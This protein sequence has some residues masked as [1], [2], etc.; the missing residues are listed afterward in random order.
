LKGGDTL[1]QLYENLPTPN[2]R[3]KIFR[4]VSVFG[5]ENVRVFDFESAVRGEG[6]II[7]AFAREAGLSAHSAEFLASRAPR[8]NES[9]SLEAARILDSLNRRR[10]LFAASGARTTGRAGPQ[11]EL[12]YIRRI[13]GRKFDV[14]GWVKQEIA[15]RSREDVA[16]LNETFGLDLYRDVFSEVSGAVEVPDAP[17]ALSDAAVDGIAEVLGELVAEATFHRALEQ[18]R[19]ALAR[20]NLVRAER[21]LR[22]AARLDPDAAQPKKLLAEAAEAASSNSKSADGETARRVGGRRNVGRR[23]P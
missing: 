9:L 8:Y 6:G 20:G 17:Q 4:A 16:W 3:A 18:G 14:P 21:R 1:Q 22:E 5:R 2:Y 12:T 7:G 23:S 11:H 19:Q 13:E 15:P 10:P